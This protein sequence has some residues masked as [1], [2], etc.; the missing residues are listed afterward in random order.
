M[1]KITEFFKTKVPEFF[2]GKAVGFYIVIADIVL[3][4][5]LG[6][7]F[8][9]T[10]QGAM[11]NNATGN[12]PELIGIGLFLGAVLDILTL[13][14]VEYKFVHIL[15]IAAYSVALM[16]EIYLIP[17]LIVDQINGIAYQGG[18]FP[19]NLF[20]L[21]TLFVILISA[22]VATFLGL[23]TKKGEEE[24]E[25][26]IKA[27][28]RFSK[29]NII[30]ITSGSL[31][32]VVAIV[33][34]VSTGVGINNST[35]G[36]NP[37]QTV[38]LDDIQKEWQ[39]KT[40]D[41]DFDP[42]SVIWQEDTH[43]YKEATAEQIIN[44]VSASPNRFL[45][46][47]VYEF[48]GKY[49]E[50]YQ[51]NFTYTY[52]YI[53]LWEDGLYNGTA[54]GTPI[55]GYWYN[56]TA[57]GTPCLVLKD[58]AGNDMV[59]ESAGN[60]SYY[61]Y[62]GDLR[63]SVN[64]GRTTK[65]NGFLYTPA[66]G[67]YLD[68]GDADLNYEFREEFDTS[69]WTVNVIRNDLRHSSILNPDEVTWTMPDMTKAGEQ[70]VKASWL[71]ESEGEEPF[72]TAVTITVG[73]DT[74]E[75]VFDTSASEVKKEYRYVDLFD[76]TGIR[77]TRKTETKTESIDPATIEHE[78]D[79]DNNCITFHLTNGKDYKM[80]VTYK[81]GAADNTLTG[82]FDG[83]DVSVVITSPTSATITAGTETAT[84]N[85]TMEGDKGLATIIVGDKTSGSDTAYG[86]L[87]E[88]L[89]IIERDGSL[90]I[91]AEIFMR[92]STLANSTNQDTDTFFIF[93]EDPNMV[94]V[95]WHFVYQGNS[96]NQYMQCS[97]R[98]DNDTTLTLTGLVGTDSV[99]QWQW[100]TKTFYN[101][102]DC[103]QSDLPFY[104]Y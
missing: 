20:Y 93:G 17:N 82:S 42:A 99:N 2:K 79:Y 77:V 47:K 31:V 10:Y 21:I 87:P 35:K 83:Q 72:E 26:K 100:S 41:Y 11:A 68:Y 88:T 9:C 80:P 5:V 94:T 32:A 62:M 46:H 90:E 18:N 12:L 98:W 37:G 81:L 1:Q 28:G 25:E 22:I 60:T 67:I 59:C 85:I 78:F 102:T 30:K 66:I 71:N 3:A 104:P 8:F 54:A 24:T 101:V 92:S 51:G 14:F 103:S 86:L 64:G 97:Y 58:T 96:N 44:N 75:Y 52:S 61:D 91:T 56:R 39:D 55:Y 15:A 65:M 4:I 23:L 43:P 40:I 95:L 49:T 74:A 50:A 36:Q 33:A 53:Y 34:A 73:E 19:L 48:E 70:E 13:V 7:V 29:K 84:F 89:N 16:K 6:I 69:T 45:H 38:V 27:E 57:S 63:T 76:P